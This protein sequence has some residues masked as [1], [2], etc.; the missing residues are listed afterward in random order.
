MQRNSFPRTGFVQALQVTIGLLTRRPWLSV[1]LLLVLG[2]LA[3]QASLIPLGA[4]RGPKPPPPPLLVSL[5]KTRLGLETGDGWSKSVALDE[6][7]TYWMGHQP[8][9]WEELR[10]GQ[11]VQVRDERLPCGTWVAREIRILPPA[12]APPPPRGGW[13]SVGVGLALALVTYLLW[14][15]SRG[16]PPPSSPDSAQPETGRS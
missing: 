9:R 5:E 13:S 14:A 15:R 2:G 16:G 8:A 6:R 7:T 3:A 12:P 10:I 4:A 11:H 1:A